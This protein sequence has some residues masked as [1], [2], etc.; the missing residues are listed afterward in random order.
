MTMIQCQ[1]MLRD[2]P[3][4]H[5]VPAKSLATA[6]GAR[7]ATP[8]GAGGNHGH[9]PCHICQMSHPRPTSGI[10][11]ISLTEPVTRCL[12]RGPRLGCCRFHSPNLSHVVT[13]AVRSWDPADV[14][15]PLRPPPYSLDKAWG[16]AGALAS[17]IARAV[18]PHDAKPSTW[19]TQSEALAETQT[20]Q[21]GVAFGIRH[22]QAPVAHI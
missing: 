20:P 13:S 22:R 1:L 17:S 8:S 16:D 14:G 11:Q 12:I 19:W 4:P 9:R 3:P 2:V 15:Q 5:R 6:R 18:L 21:G 10:L 7:H